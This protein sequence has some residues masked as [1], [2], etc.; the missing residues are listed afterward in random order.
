MPLATVQERQLQLHTGMETRKIVL[1]LLAATLAM[2]AS[3]KPEEIEKP[4]EKPAPIPSLAT[5]SGCV[6]GSD[7]QKL[8]G[9]VVSDGH[10][11]AKTNQDGVYYLNSSLQDVD[12]VIVS[13]PSG[14]SAPVADALPVFFKRLDGLK[15]DASGKYTGV[16]FTLEKVSN[17][18]RYTVFFSGDPQPRSSTAG[19]DKIGYH[20]FDCVDDMCRDFRETAAAISKDRPVYGIVLGDVCHNSIALFPTYKS[21]IKTNGFASYHVIGNHDHDL[22]TEGDRESAAAFEKA[23]GPT[24]YSFNL[25]GVHFVVLDNMMVVSGKRSSNSGSD[26]GDGLR[27][28]IYQ[29]LEADLALADKTKPLVICTHSPM[30]MGMG[31]SM[32]TR[33]AI[34]FD[35]KKVSN[36][37]SDVDQLIKSFPKVYAWAGHTHTT[38]NYVDTQNAPYVESHTVARVTGELWTNEYQ[39]AGT[40]RGY[41]I[42]DYDNGEISWRFHPIRYQSGKHCMSIQPNYEH[43][44]WV[45]DATGVARMKIGGKDLDDSYQMHLYAPNTYKD[46]DNLVYANI[47]MW[48]NL[49]QTPTFTYDGVK[50]RMKRYTDN[51]NRYYDFANWENKTWYKANSSTLAGADYD[52]S[53]ANVSTIFTASVNTKY[54]AG[55]NTGTVSV[56]DRFGNTYTSTITW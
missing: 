24:N 52:V 29:W 16:D 11:C 56:Q 45:Y 46:Q 20:S 7:G 17:P 36:H 6:T 35:G 1:I 9:V 33:S 50:T 28:D 41:V 3:C 38:Y 23:F 42:M 51:K 40:P 44:D 2:L 21:K 54:P 4:I 25:G 27:D 31:E 8:K 34:T 19:Y 55:K 26:L 30:F 5:I 49:W 32:R 13:T 22:N 37:Y 18:N 47:F 14:Y 10:I 12:F 39:S 48:D 43:R 15:R 53:T